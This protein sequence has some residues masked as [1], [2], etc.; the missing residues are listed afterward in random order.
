MGLMMGMRLTTLCY[1][2]DNGKYLMLHRTK[3]KN[4]QSQGKW[5]GV[6]GKMENGESPEDC[7]RREVREETGFTVTDYIFAGVITFISDIYEAEHMF[8]YVVTGF[9]GGM[10]ECNEGDLAWIDKQ[11]VMKL[12]LW[13]GD[14]IFL[15]L[16]SEERYGFSIRYVYHGDELVEVTGNITSEDIAVVDKYRKSED[17]SV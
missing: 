5:L 12:N 8:I 4:D 9:T 14:R 1:I 7:M 15:K 17:G 10:I 2:E 16:L 3:K 13:E 11:E 6:G